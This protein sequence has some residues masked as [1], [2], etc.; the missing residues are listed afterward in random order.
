MVMV[1]TDGR[2]WFAVVALMST[3]DEVVVGLLERRRR[4][5]PEHSARA[6][7]RVE[8]RMFISVEALGVSRGSV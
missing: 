4:Q 3:P 2:N 7:A 6:P 1:I 5:L 8:H